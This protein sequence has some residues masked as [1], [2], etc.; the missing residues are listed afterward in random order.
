MET[1]EE[2][3]VTWAV[4]L[5][6]HHYY[7]RFLEG[8]INLDPNNTNAVSKISEAKL[9]FD[10]VGDHLLQKT[11]AVE[12]AETPKQWHF[13]VLS[14]PRIRPS[15]LDLSVPRAIF[16]Q[17][18]GCWHLHPRTVDV[19]LSNNGIL[20]S[21][22]CPASGRKSAVWRVASSRSTGFDCVSVSSNPATRTTYVL[23]HHL[24]DEDAV[25]GALLAMPE[26]CVD[27]YFFVSV[28]YWSH[29]QQIEAHRNVID[30]AVLGIERRTRFGHPGRLMDD[31][32]G[33][34]DFDDHCSATMEDPK[35]TIRQLSYCQTDLAVI[36]H[37]ARAC[38]DAGEQL[39]RAIEEDQR[40]LSLLMDDDDDPL[41]RNARPGYD[42]LAEALTITRGDVE[43]TRRRTAMLL[44]QVQQM[45]DRSQSQTSFMLGDL[46]QSEAEYTAAIAIDTKR[47][48]VAMRT[49]AA[50]GIVFLPGTFVA[51]LFSVDMFDWGSGGG[52]GESAS[53]SATTESSS[54]VRALPG[55]WIYWAIAIPLTI[56]TFLVWVLWSRREN[57]KSDR[58]LRIRRTKSSGPSLGTSVTAAVLRSVGL[59]RGEQMV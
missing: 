16:Q 26:R 9:Q 31:L 10:E 4:P 8:S 29:H 14:L 15:A 49:I 37:V 5:V 22:D 36:G 43:Y 32:G 48:S 6:G 38:L 7:L 12:D 18:Q 20:T 47:D 46:A 33:R 41:E 2:R 53:S 35:T 30:D 44:S 58:R 25:F 1:R 57:Q 24:A 13:K 50:L 54:G 40:K 34:P 23:Y 42:R 51:T 19:F 21:A 39:V 56:R 17:I 52:G 3:L 45:K 55:M 11:A 59:A 28:L 27:H